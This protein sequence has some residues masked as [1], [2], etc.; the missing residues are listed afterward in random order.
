M[1][2]VDKA[3]ETLNKLKE[4]NKQRAVKYYEKNKEAIKI[5]RREVRN[6][7]KPKTLEQVIETLNA[8]E[9]PKDTIKMY[10]DSAKRLTTIKHN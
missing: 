3:I 1:S 9:S 2:D 7:K 6:S 8:M 5:K 4:Q 10:V